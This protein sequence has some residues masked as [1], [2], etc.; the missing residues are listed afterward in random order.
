M[1]KQM[2]KIPYFEFQCTIENVFV[3]TQ[4]TAIKKLH[5]LS[6][7]E[8]VDANENEYMQTHHITISS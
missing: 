1:T 5:T 2:M 6:H 4:S 7:Y 8:W 3:C